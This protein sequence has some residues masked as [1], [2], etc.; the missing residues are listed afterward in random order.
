MPTAPQL[1]EQ[2]NRADSPGRSRPA[3]RGPSGMTLGLVSAPG[4]FT[5]LG[6]TP[7]LTRYALSRFNTAFNAFSTQFFSNILFF[8]F[9]NHSRITSPFPFHPL[10]VV[11]SASSFPYVYFTR[12]LCFPMW[13]AKGKHIC[14]HVLPQMALRWELQLKNRNNCQK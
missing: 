12:Y 7:P 4:C 11:F 1:E 3:A 6:V 14:P 10:A 13:C 9:I 5:R 8:F 2:Q